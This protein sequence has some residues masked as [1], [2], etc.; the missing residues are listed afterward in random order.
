MHVL[1]AH[2]PS[3]RMHARGELMRVHARCRRAAHCRR[4]H[5]AR[6]CRA[7]EE[8][9][10]APAWRGG[11]QQQG[12]EVS[13]EVELGE[14]DS[15]FAPLSA[16][17]PRCLPG[18]PTD[19]AGLRGHATR[20]ER[21]EATQGQPRGHLEHRHGCSLLREREVRSYLCGGGGARCARMHARW[22]QAA[23]G[24]HP[25]AGI[26]SGV[27]VWG[28]QACLQ[29]LRAARCGPPH[30]SLRTR[31]QCGLLTC[32]AGTPQGGLAG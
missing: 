5:V 32:A 29:A 6:T 12:W 13:A 28:V 21:P 1:R 11:G 2:A 25:T 31:A 30:P 20:G 10:A 14:R 16:R 27:G 19:V 26:A 15:G 23:I 3:M 8:L 7:E 22:A 24:R 4:T 18:T 9:A 17:P